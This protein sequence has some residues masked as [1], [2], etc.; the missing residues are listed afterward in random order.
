MEMDEFQGSLSPGNPFFKWEIYGL[1]FL[2]MNPWIPYSSKHLDWDCLWS[3]LA[4]GTPSHR[5]FGALGADIMEYWI[6][7]WE[8]WNRKPSVSPPIFDGK[9]PWFPVKI[10]LE[11]I[12]WRGV[13]ANHAAK[14]MPCLPPIFL[15]MGIVH[16]TSILRVT[17][18]VGHGIELNPTLDLMDL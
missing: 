6:A 10:S 3:C 7:W 4:W 14:T 5:L 12:H 17:W 13:W 8:N 11:P 18:G 16:T 15:G 9:N 1:W 2:T